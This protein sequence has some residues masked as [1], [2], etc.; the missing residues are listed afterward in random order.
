MIKTSTCIKLLGEHS[1]ICCARI[2]LICIGNN[3]LACA[4]VNEILLV[5]WENSL[6]SSIPIFKDISF[7]IHC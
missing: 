1:A 3:Y 5:S 7:L 2:Y 4:M 6:S